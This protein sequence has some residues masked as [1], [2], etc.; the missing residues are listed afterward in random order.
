YVIAVSGRVKQRDPQ[1]VNRN[2]ATGEVELIA[3]DLR[4]LNTSQNPPFLPSEA[5]VANEELRLRYRYLDLRR[6]PMQANI[7]LRHK[8]AL[9][10]RQYLSSRSFFEIDFFFN[11]TS[12]TE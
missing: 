11:N 6:D 5:V 3:Q 2:I 7:E 1:T 9:A 12:T 4:L 10:I 8:V